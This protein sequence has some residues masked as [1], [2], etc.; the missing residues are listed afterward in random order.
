M[1]FFKAKFRKSILDIFKNVQ[2]PKGPSDPR[3]N[4]AKFGFVTE[5]LSFS[6]KD[7]KCCEHNFLSI[8]CKNDLGIFSC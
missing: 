6:K 7:Q 8:F 2:K 4:L 1:I 5:M 3:K